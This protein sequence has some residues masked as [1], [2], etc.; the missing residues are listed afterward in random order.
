MNKPE[1][2]HSPIPGM[3]YRLN[4]LIACTLTGADDFTDLD[5]L[6]ALSKEYP[7]VEWGV[8]Y[9]TSNQGKG[10]RYPSFAWIDALAERLSDPDAPRF[11]L[12]ICGSAVGE[13]LRGVGHITRVAERFSRIQLNF[14]HADFLM[15]QIRDALD[16][17]P[18][19]TIITQYNLSNADLWLSLQD[20]YNHAVLFDESGGRGASPTHWPQSLTIASK[21]RGPHCGYAGG[22]GPDN[23][24]EALPQI[25]AS[26]TRPYWIDMESKLRNE[27][28]RFDLTRATICLSKVATFLAR[29]DAADM[30]EALQTEINLLRALSSGTESR[31]A[32]AIR[33]AL[34]ELVDLKDLKNSI[35]AGVFKTQIALAAATEDYDRRQPAAWT[36]AREALL[37]RKALSACSGR[38]AH[39]SSGS[40]PKVSCACA[41]PCGG[42][43]NAA[44]AIAHREASEQEWLG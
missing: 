2:A 21:G 5:A 11:A 43:T 31:Q 17:H 10:G 37:P 33:A 9:S 28:D 4:H 14:R 24:T 41:K 22:L 42:H 8:L 16:R 29:T 40:E 39:D 15:D 20:K 6:W 44:P 25:Q 32:L 1:N 13:F 7:F 36:A 12:H 38:C 27:H 34:V 23:L 30:E 35:T 3:R 19:Q 26:A 18:Y